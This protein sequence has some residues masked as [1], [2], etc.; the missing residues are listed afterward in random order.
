MLDIERTKVP[1]ASCWAVGNS[2][3]SRLDCICSSM[4]MNFHPAGL[5]DILSSK[6]SRS[7]TSIF[8]TAQ[9][10]ILHIHYLFPYQ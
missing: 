2:Y 6:T 9:R 4:E 10:S 7:L 8:K 5:H 3:Y 1:L